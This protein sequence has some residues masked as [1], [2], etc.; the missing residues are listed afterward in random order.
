MQ[1]FTAH[2]AIVIFCGEVA[3]IDVGGLSP[4]VVMKHECEWWWN[5][6]KCKGPILGQCISC[7]R[8]ATDEHVDLYIKLPTY[9]G[10]VFVALSQGDWR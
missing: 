4:Q 6:Q 9:C 10:H 3:L 7:S 2:G 8:Q 5:F 1:L